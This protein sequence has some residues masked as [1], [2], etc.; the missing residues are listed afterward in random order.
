MAP[1]A[2]V[3][4]TAAPLAGLGLMRAACGVTPAIVARN[5]RSP[6]SCARD[7]PFTVASPPS[8][9][10]S[11]KTTLIPRLSAPWWSGAPC[12][13]VL[14]SDAISRKPLEY[15]HTLRLD[16]AKELLER[17]ELLVDA[18]ASEVGYRDAS[19]FC[20]LFR[21]KWGAPHPLTAC[22]SALSA[23]RW[24]VRPSIQSPPESDLGLASIRA[25]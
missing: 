20:R 19:S 9:S 6:S 18:I 5:C 21:R 17:T 25:G 8:R 7:R 24:Q 1:R 4:S 15:V 11:P 3:E 23:R 14:S 16:E 22:A 2:A 13:G 12:P 10:W